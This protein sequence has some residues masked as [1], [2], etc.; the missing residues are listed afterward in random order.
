[1]V[2][3]DRE[4]FRRLVVNAKGGRFHARPAAHH[5]ECAYTLSRSRFTI[6]RT[7]F[8]PRCRVGP[9]LPIGMFSSWAMA[10]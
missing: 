4:A 8:K 5:A 10:A 3:D 2:N 9:M 1:M 7:F 6:V